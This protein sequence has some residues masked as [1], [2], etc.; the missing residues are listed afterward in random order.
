VAVTLYVRA[1]AEPLFGT[2]K[3]AYSGAGFAGLVAVHVCELRLHFHPAGVD[4][5]GQASEAP[6]WIFR[7]TAVRPAAGAT[8]KVR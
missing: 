4:L 6:Y 1:A 5:I 7:V 2:T 8:L 3:S